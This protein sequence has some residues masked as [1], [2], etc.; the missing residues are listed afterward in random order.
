MKRTVL[1][2]MLCLTLV[3][4]VGCKNTEADG[5]ESDTVESLHDV[6]DDVSDDAS[7]AQD[8]DSKSEELS[9]SPES[10]FEYTVKTDKNGDKSITITKYIGTSDRVVIPSTIEGLPVRSIDGINK[11]SYNMVFENSTVKSVVIPDSVTK[12]QHV[13]L[14]CKELTQ[15]VFGENSELETI[16]T[17]FKNC[18]SLERIDLSTTKLKY[19]GMSFMGCTSL[20]EIKFCDSIKLIGEQAFYECSSLEELDLPNDLEDIEKYAF[21]GCKSLKSIVVPKKLDLVNK[22][23]IPVFFGESLEKIIFDEGREDILGYGFFDTKT[24]AEIIIPKSVK[25]IDPETFFIHGKAKIIFLGDCPKAY[26]SPEYIIMPG[27]EPPSLAPVYDIK[28]YGEPT[29]YYDPS[30]KGWDNCPWE[31]IHPIKPIEQ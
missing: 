13:F 21:M 27:T 6:S 25:E 31:G 22:G 8:E 9:E 14:E 2:L 23:P 17:S 1:L 7:G 12:M 29:I 3:S 16:A 5:S 15:V 26:H 24:D 11:G 20:K 4:L 18:T 19:I 30:T 10:D 28:F